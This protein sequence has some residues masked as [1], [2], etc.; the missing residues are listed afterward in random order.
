MILP[1]KHTS[2]SESLFGLGAILLKSL[3]VPRTV[4][5]LWWDFQ[6]VNNS[7]RFPAYHGFDNVV[8]ALDYLFCVG[9]I[10]INKKGEI[11]NAIS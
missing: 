6:N 1:S 2:F 9:A 10:D 3:N 7:Y 5:E 8:L 11:F 4:D